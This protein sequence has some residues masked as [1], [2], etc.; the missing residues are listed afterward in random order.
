M[1]EMNTTTPTPTPPRSTDRKFIE[2]NRR[3]QMKALCSKLNSLLPHH[4]A[5]T[6]QVTPS[7]PDQLEEATRYIK[8]LQ[9]KLEKLREKKHIL[10]GI[11]DHN[12]NNNNNIVGSKSPQIEIHHVGSGLEVAVTTGLD[13]QFIFNEILR[14]LHEEG[15]DIVSAAYTVVDDAVG[16]GSG[17]R[18]VKISERLKRFL[19]GSGG[20]F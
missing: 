13:S 11:M 1:M 14:V 16:E 9:M 6:D 20:G 10:M 5:S 17:N 18:A 3:N 8:K 15:A 19:Y 7:V 12:N 2:R 4:Q